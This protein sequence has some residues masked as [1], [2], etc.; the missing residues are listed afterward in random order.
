MVRGAVRPLPA[1]ARGP[2]APDPLRER[3]HSRQTNTTPVEVG[4]GT[5][6]FTDLFKRRIVMPSAGPLAE[7]G[8]LL[9]HEVGHAALRD[10]GDPYYFPCRWGHAFFAFA[11]GRWGDAKVAEL[12]KAAGGTG[13]RGGPLESPRS[14]PEGAA[15]R[16][17][18]VA[19]LR[20]RLQ[21]GGPASRPAITGPPSSPRRTRAS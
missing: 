4:E 20:L 10:L 11:G 3:P 12:L 17:A 16:V 14:G 8:H 9:G 15:E 2:T 6:G 5:R 19:A 1:S 21:L 13:G 18:R 7:T